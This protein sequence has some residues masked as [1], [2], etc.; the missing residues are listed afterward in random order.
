MR[1]F[2]RRNLCT[3][4]S[5]PSTGRSPRK[6]GVVRPFRRLLLPAGL[7]LLLAPT[8]LAAESKATFALNAVDAGREGYFVY[9]SAPGEVVHGEVEVVNAGTRAGVARLDVVDATTGATTGA[10]YE[11]LEETPADVGA[12]V[13]LSEHRLTLDAGESATV[14]FTLTVP[15][16]ARRGEHLGGIVA[17]PVEPTPAAA[18]GGKKGSFRVNVVNQAI[19]AIQ[20]DLPGDARQKLAVR[21]VTAGGNPGYQTLDLALSNPGERIV[22]GTGNVEILQDDGSVFSTQRFTIDTFLPRTR[23]EYPLVLRGD[24]LVPGDYRARIALDW[25]EGRTSEELPFS[26]SRKEI[27]QAFGSEGLAKLPDGKGSG[28]GGGLMI[29]VLGVAFVLLAGMGWMLVSFRRRTRRLEE[30]IA[31]GS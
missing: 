15:G 28:G 29:V 12:W 1:R 5:W 19:L 24:A 4:K 26:V 6:N 3:L 16:D 30:R 9:H 13:S 23:I 20:V 7:L 2:P 22:R 11:G 25:G 27:E 17:V 31:A 10:V 18:G 8:A 21:G 14:A